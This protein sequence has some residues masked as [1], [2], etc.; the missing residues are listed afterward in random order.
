M[1]CLKT[2]WD[3][4]LKNLLRI[5]SVICLELTIFRIRTLDTKEK[6][7]EKLYKTKIIETKKHFQQKLET[8]LK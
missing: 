4:K 5:C 1:A 3:V 2:I 7:A 6:L 8:P